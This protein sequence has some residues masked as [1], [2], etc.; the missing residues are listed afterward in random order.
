VEPNIPV[1]PATW[2]KE[3]GGSRSEASRANMKTKLKQKRVG[4]GERHGSSSRVLI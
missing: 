3:V 4:M 1:I 2:E